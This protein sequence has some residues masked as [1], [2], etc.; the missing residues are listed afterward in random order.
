M[1]ALSI[2][3]IN[4]LKDKNEEKFDHD[5]NKRMSSKIG[6]RNTWI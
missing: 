5:R 1:N 4:I 3:T 2:D 6:N